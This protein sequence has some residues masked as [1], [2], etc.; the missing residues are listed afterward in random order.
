MVVFILNGFNTNTLKSIRIQIN[1]TENTLI[2]ISISHSN[3]QINAWARC[4]SNPFQPAK[5][6]KSQSLANCLTQI[7][8][9]KAE[10]C[11]SKL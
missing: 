3:I 4:L 2:Y 1:N 6:S 10:M 11:I 9:K 8:T 7:K 5:N